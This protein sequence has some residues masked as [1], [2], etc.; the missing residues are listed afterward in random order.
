MA[1]T[2]ASS[3]VTDTRGVAAEESTVF[4]PTDLPKKAPCEGVW[5]AVAARSDRRRKR[6]PDAFRQRDGAQ[7]GEPMMPRT[8][9]TWP[10]GNCALQARRPDVP[11]RHHE[12][13][14]PALSC[15]QE[16]W[17]ASQGN[18]PPCVSRRDLFYRRP[19]EVI[20]G[21]T[22]IVAVAIKLPETKEARV[23]ARGLLVA[24]VSLPCYQPRYPPLPKL[25]VTPGPP[26]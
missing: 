5:R 17:R 23:V 7:G 16:R 13:Q 10:R 20:E 9:R 3:H 12:R 4:M 14:M 26:P 19:N 15:W 1:M 6:R 8:R 2:W 18:K 24:V 25:K 22:R 11:G 21:G